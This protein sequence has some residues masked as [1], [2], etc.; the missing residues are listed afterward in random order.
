LALLPA[1][2]QLV[3]QWMLPESPRWLV[4]MGK[5]DEAARVL[6]LMSGRDDEGGVELK[7]ICD[8]I[9]GEGKVNGGQALMQLWQTTRLRRAT[10][11]GILLMAMQQFSGINTVM[12]YSGEL[13]S[14]HFPREATMWLSSLCV[15]SQL[16]GVGICVLWVDTI[17]RRRT[18]LRSIVA[19]VITLCIL[20]TS[21]TI[22]PSIGSD[23]F[24]LLAI[25]AYLIAYGCGMSTVPWIMNAEIYPMSVR[26]VGLAQAA[27]ANWLFNF[28]ISQSFL[29]ICS[30]LGKPAAFFALAAFS[31]LFALVAGR[32][33]PET[34]GVPLETVPTL[35]DDPYPAN[36]RS[37]PTMTKKRLRWHGGLGA[38]TRR[39]QVRRRHIQGWL[40]G[41]VGLRVGGCWGG[42]SAG[43]RLEVVRGQGSRRVWSWNPPTFKNG[44]VTA[45]AFALMRGAR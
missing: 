36:V 43:S 37:R 7:E 30:A 26:S 20:A 28:A 22:N 41:R 4:Q 31:T 19:S 23:I 13:L 39:K 2:M 27:G 11:V 45:G 33:L 8:A 32:Y 40:L 10:L 24:V 44:G 34:M 17:G 15:V 1:L 12:Y 35:F 25:I 21:F 14:E 38:A 18:A 16:A 9:Q 6:R 29:N 3:G 5:M 42:G